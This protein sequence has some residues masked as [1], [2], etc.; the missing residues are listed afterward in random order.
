M[1]LKLM[2][3]LIILTGLLALSVAPVFGGFIAKVS[4]DPDFVHVGKFRG[5]YMVSS[6]SGKWWRWGLARAPVEEPRAFT[7]GY[8]DDAIAIPFDT[9]GRV[10]FAPVYIYTIRPENEQKRRLEALFE[11]VTSQAD[12]RRIF[13]RPAIQGNVRGYQ[14]WYYEI[15]VYNPFEEFPDI[16]G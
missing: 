16:R 9:N 1:D 4:N 11:G 12:V 6:D 15:Q 2:R 13:G 7:H 14:V 8:G 10:V 5:Y 3:R